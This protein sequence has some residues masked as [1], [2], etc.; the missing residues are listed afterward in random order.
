M[1]KISDIKANP[2]LKEFIETNDSSLLG[3]MWAMYWRLLAFAF[4]VGFF[5]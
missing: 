5:F 3:L 1:K 4:I 2:K